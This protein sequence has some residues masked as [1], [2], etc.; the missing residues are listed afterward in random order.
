MRQLVSFPSKITSLYNVE[1]LHLSVLKKKKKP[2]IQP[3][4]LVHH[5]QFWL[6]FTLLYIS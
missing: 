6:Y 4:S 3:H 2:Q 1:E 5:L